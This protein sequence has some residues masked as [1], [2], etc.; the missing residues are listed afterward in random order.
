[1]KHVIAL[2]VIIASAFS[3][4]ASD[5]DKADK[6]KWM[7]EMQQHQ[8][9][10]IARELQ[11]TDK[12]RADFLPLYNKM[13]SEIFDAGEAARKK[14]KTVKDKADA[15]TEA[16]YEAATQAY[17]DVR[18]RESEIIKTYYKKFSHIL[19]RKQLFNLDEA[20]RKFD[21]MLMSHRRGDGG[22]GASKGNRQNN[23]K[24]AG[25]QNRK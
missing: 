17:L 3:M 18:S 2:I 13:R 1:M 4:V 14:A 20:Q 21:R 12:Q 5:H 9:D 7:Q 15:A 10:F 23:K 25:R 24:G 16:D 6:E 11:L 22:K 19:S 8:N